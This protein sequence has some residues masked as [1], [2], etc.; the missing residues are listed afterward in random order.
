MRRAALLALMLAGIASGHAQ[1]RDPAVEAAR[2]ELNALGARLE[3]AD[4]NYQHR[5]PLLVQHIE[6]IK[7]NYPPSQWAAQ[8]ERIYWSLPT[9]ADFMRAG[10]P[11]PLAL[12]IGRPPMCDEI[13]DARR[14]FED[15]AADLLRCTQSR[16]YE[17]DCL[18]Q[19]RYARDASGEFEE[20]VSDPAAFCGR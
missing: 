19:L 12:P 7:L 2:V 5:F 4:P 13:E 10:G 15:A 8:A 1:V 9:P 18:R 16:N 3:R 17:N 14:E 20:A 11:I 6:R